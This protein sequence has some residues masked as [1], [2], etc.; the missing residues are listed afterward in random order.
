MMAAS[1]ASECGLSVILIEKN[2][3]LGKKLLITGGGRCNITNAEFDLR[4]FLAKLGKTGNFL[5]STFSQFGV[6]DTLI[7]LRKKDWLSKS[8]N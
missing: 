3:E 2:A 4:A 8:R 7:F 5:F 6:K 1:R